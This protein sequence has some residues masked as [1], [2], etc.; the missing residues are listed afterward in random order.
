MDLFVVVQEYL[1]LIIML[2]FI[3]F[4]MDIFYKY[5]RYG[6]ITPKKMLTFKDGGLFAYY[7]LVGILT[8]GI[9]V[10][11]AVFNVN[12]FYGTP[13]AFFIE[14][15]SFLFLLGVFLV[16]VFAFVIYFIFA[17]IAKRKNADMQEYMNY[18]IR[19]IINLSIF[20]GFTLATLIIGILL[21][22]ELQIGT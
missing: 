8:L 10:L 3:T 22:A 13:L 2:F 11:H 1:S 19:F 7:K 6:R 5:A 15:V 4:F 17:M 9:G 21:L 16:F 20:F 12:P 14:F 18:K